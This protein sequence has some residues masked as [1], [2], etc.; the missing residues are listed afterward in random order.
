MRGNRVALYHNFTL[1]FEPNTKARKDGLLQKFTTVRGYGWKDALSQADRE[2]GLYT[3]RFI[4]HPSND[5]V[6]TAYDEDGDIIGQVTAV[7]A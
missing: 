7:K 2:F 4:T 5:G 3:T 6:A 1:I